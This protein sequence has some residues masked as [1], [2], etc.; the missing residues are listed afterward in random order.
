MDLRQ[1]LLALRARYELALWVFMLATVGAMV[2]NALMPKRYTSEVLV[3]VDIRSPDPVGA[4]LMLPPTMIPGNMSTQTEIIQSD[5]VARKVV[6]LLRLDEDPSSKEAW[7]DATDGK[8]RLE[9]WIAR[10][11]QKGLKVSPSRDSNVVSIAYQGADARIA[12]DVAN[13][14]AQAYI[15]ASIELKVE[16][17]RQYAKWFGDQSKVLRQQVER[18]QARLTEFQ[19]RKGIV[20]T[21]E[22]VDAEVARLNDLAAR[23]SVAQ[24]ETRE[25]QSRQLPVRSTADILPEVRQD[26]VVVT[27]R[28]NI[29]Q[30]EA[31]I[32]EAAGNLGTQH[33]QYQ[34][35]QSELAELKTR[36]AAEARSVTGG[37]AVSSVAGRTREA[38]LK[39]ALEAQK[40]KVLAMKREHDEIAVLVRDVET[41]RRAYDA[42]TNRLNQTTL[43]SQATRANVSVLAPAVEP[44]APSF[45]KPFVKMLLFAV[46]LGIVAA[47]ASV[48][49]LEMID[50]RVRS[51]DDLE[52]MLQMPVLAVIEPPGR[53]GTL[54]HRRPPALPSM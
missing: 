2:A 50:R 18:A 13:A 6:K 33:P 29:A 1:F 12:A 3:M 16:P 51:V 39:A 53:R 38:D 36:L 32:K 46:I 31:K 17:A 35:M 47:G 40:R 8:G 52:E 27:L 42:V 45:P 44:L 11:L 22:S 7:L 54:F 49:G 4:A 23:L 20:G 37:Y 10:G 5:L 48:V 26:A 43:E 14:F 24:G 30:L 34:R 25:A 9:D 15:D 41:A 19:Q 28:A 21:A